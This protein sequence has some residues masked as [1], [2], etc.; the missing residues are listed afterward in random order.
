MT[1]HPALA[2]RMPAALLSGLG[3]QAMQRALAGP[4]RWSGR[5]SIQRKPLSDTE[6]LELTVE[7]FDRHRKGEQMDWANQAFGGPARQHVWEIVEWGLDGLAGL[8]L[9][10]VV[11]AMATP[12]HR[13]YI[14][15]YCEA[16]NGK[17]DGGPTVELEPQT[18]LAGV[19]RHGEWVGTL[20]ALLT[21][22][23]IRAVLPFD[24]FDKLVADEAVAKAFVAYYTN[25]KPILQASDGEDTSAFIKLVGDEKAKITDYTGELTH[26]KNYHKFHKASLDKLRTDKTTPGKPLT[27]VFQSLYDHNG[28]FIRHEHVKAVIQN[29]NV[30]AYA[31][32]GQSEA[33]IKG[34]AK[35]GLAHLAAAYGL[36]GKITQVM[37]AGH[38]NA[39]AMDFGGEGTDVEHDK[40]T[41]EHTVEPEDAVD[42]EFGADHREFWTAFFE[43]LFSNM[44]MKGGLKP[45]VLLRACLTASNEV[46]VDKLEEEMATDGRIDLRDS[47]VDPKKPENQVKIRAGIV[48]YIKRHGS[49]AKLIGDQAGTRADVKGA[50]ASITTESSGSIHEGTGQLDIV[51]KDDPHVAG[52]K[53]TY[54]RHGKEPQG[55]MRAVIESWAENDAACFAAIEERLKDPPGSTDSEF[56]I[57]TLYT[58]V[59]TT[60][61]NDILTA[62]GLCDTASVLDNVADGDDDCRPKALRKDPMM[63]QLRFTLYPVLMGRFANKNAK[64]AIYQDWLSLD[65]AKQTELIT[66]LS[67]PDFKRKEVKDYLDFKALDPYVDGMLKLGAGLR[68]RITLALV[69]L[70]EHKRED[71]KAFLASQTEGGNAF[72][73]DVKAV[74]DGYSETELRKKLGLQAE[75]APVVSGGRPKNIAG[76]DFHVEPIH[77][78]SKST[79]NATATDVAKLLECPADGATELERTDRAQ[80]YDVVGEVKTLTGDDAGWY[81]VRRST[82]TVGYMRTKYF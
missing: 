46:D 65:A 23:R 76:G 9:G 53:L 31:I 39:T 42:L 10:D 5:P 47:N 72:T 78:K 73:A 25:Q 70:I 66:H 56:I 12:L 57:R 59:S 80:P 55:A 33:E 44:A 11:R 29:A 50:Q 16:L 28:A 20:T 37:I 1:T 51:A 4:A 27:L 64:L 18:T 74:L 34:L 38:G 61:R 52:P 6:M 71:C 49:L 68:G 22:P 75:G 13:L 62:N 7:D 19:L 82:G 41:G 36:D 35:T 45:T 60:Y 67:S 32:E 15:Q 26:I 43:A 8:K 21:G 48:E 58:L 14:K 79:A 63:Q 54:V 24:V 69:G 3:N 77:A 17:L 81:M 40:G 2:A 30:R